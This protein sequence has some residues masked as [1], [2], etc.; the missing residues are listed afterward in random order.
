M[1]IMMMTKSECM[2]EGVKAN[3][4][5]KGEK[6]GEDFSSRF[7]SHRIEL[8]CMGAI[9]PT[10]KLHCKCQPILTDRHTDR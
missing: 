8:E 7:R 4:A 1:M 5:M 2:W 6:L 3:M 9:S 10:A